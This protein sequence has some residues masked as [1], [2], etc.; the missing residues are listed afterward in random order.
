MMIQSILVGLDWGE[1]A[2]AAAAVAAELAIAW[3]AS[4]KALY[5]EDAELIRAAEQ[6]VL[7]GFP[8][9]GPI[10]YAVPTIPEL[11]TEFASEERAL[12][13]RFLKLVADTRIHGS[14]QV[15]QGEVDRILIRESRAHD[16]LVMGKYSQPAPEAGGRP[17]GRNVERILRHVWSPVV[18]VPP[19][20]KL[21]PNLL[22]AYDGSAGSHRA[23]ASAVRVARAIDGSLRVVAVGKPAAADALLEEAESYLDAHR[24]AAELVAREGITAQEILREVEEYEADL[25][26]M[27]AFGPARRKESFGAGVTLDVLEGVRRAALVCGSMDED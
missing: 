24:A 12:G 14:F 27:G 23:L 1:T 9:S 25:L 17:L 7:A 6:A 18:L 19:D 20:G 5:V 15:A 8:E 13:R 16:L 4:V 10:P 11:E 2:E 26:A 22:V 3:E 21:G